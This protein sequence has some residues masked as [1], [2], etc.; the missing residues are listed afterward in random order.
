MYENRTYHISM[1]DNETGNSIMN[2]SSA[3]CEHNG[4]NFPCLTKNE[5]YESITRIAILNED[6]SIAQDHEDGTV[7]G[8]YFELDRNPCPTNSTC[9]GDIQFP[10]LSDATDVD[11]NNIAN[12]VTV[13][14]FHGD[15]DYV[16]FRKDPVYK[17]RGCPR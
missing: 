13:Y 3:E 4:A 1:F 7:D 16:G 10:V 12:L 17:S 11:A 6:G 15:T 5:S 9:Y 8:R 14:S 2:Y